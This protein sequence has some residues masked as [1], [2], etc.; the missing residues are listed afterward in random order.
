MAG[1]CT[2]SRWLLLIIAHFLLVR[3]VPTYWHWTKDESQQ[4]FLLAIKGNQSGLEIRTYQLPE[5]NGYVN[6][7][8]A[9]LWSEHELKPQ[10]NF[11]PNRTLSSECGKQYFRCQELLV[12][13]QGI[14]DGTLNLNV[15]FVPLEDGV[16]VLFNKWNS[17]KL[18]WNTIIKNTTNC[19][20]TAF[21]NINSRFFMICISSHIALEV[22]VYRIKLNVF[23]PVIEESDIIIMK[24]LAK[25]YNT[26]NQSLTLNLSNF[27]VVNDKIFVAIGNIIASINVSDT[28]S[29]KNLTLKTCTQISNLVPTVDNQHGQMLV[30]LCTD[31]IVYINCDQNGDLI[32]VQ[33]YTS[34]GSVLY[35]CPDTEYKATLF[36]DTHLWLSSS[37]NII[38]VNIRSA[39][40]VCFKNR[41]RTYSA[42]SDQNQNRVFVYD[43][44]TQD[45]RSV[46]PYYCPN[47]DCPQLLVL[48]NQYL[49]VRDVNHAVVLDATNKFSLVINISGDLGDILAIPI[50]MLTVLLPYHLQS[51]VMKILLLVPFHQ[52]HQVQYSLIVVVYLKMLFTIELILIILTII[53]LSQCRCQPYLSQSSAK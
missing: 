51:L 31:S 38:T 28:D 5:N 41:N 23:D 9:R 17:T 46:S 35:V 20:P 6:S 21:Y 11:I 1:S 22:F 27:V 19:S 30:A 18:E 36:N 33:Q 50:T 44:I 48:K 3:I 32:E 10:V 37:P 7:S 16:L 29:T 24:P 40:G 43:F 34:N 42:Y 8:G 25:I 47:M 14:D 52:P 4:T 15:V 13:S 45:I 2:G 49:V 12:E 39:G 26:T 53:A